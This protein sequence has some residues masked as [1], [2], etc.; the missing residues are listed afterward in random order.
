M[1][2]LAKIREEHFLKT[3]LENLIPFGKSQ[4]NFAL[5]FWRFP[6]FPG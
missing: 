1:G 5:Q 2:D 6:G 4:A 3:L